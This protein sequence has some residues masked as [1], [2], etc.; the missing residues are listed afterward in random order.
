MTEEDRMNKVRI[1]LQH[2]GFVLW[3]NNVGVFKLQGRQG[4]IFCGLCKGSS[5]LVGFY[6]KNRMAKPIF[7]G[8]EIK[9]SSDKLTQSQKNF[10]SFIHFSGG[11]A[12]VG[13]FDKFDE[14]VNYKLWNYETT[15]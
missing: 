2:L 9:S 7:S 14:K 10:L 4:Y 11:V 6:K 3:R 15:R 5:D 13:R 12:I 1:D 8:V